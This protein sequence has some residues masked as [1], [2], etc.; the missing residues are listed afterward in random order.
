L[1]LFP[2]HSHACV[3]QRVTPL[4]PAFSLLHP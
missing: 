1:S 2:L 3:L 4:L